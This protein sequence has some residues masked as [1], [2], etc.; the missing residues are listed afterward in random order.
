MADGIVYIVDDDSDAK[1]AVAAIVTEMGVEA[2]TYASAEAFLEAYRGE[3][4][5][6]LV[7]DVRMLHMSGLELQE[8][9]AAAGET[10]SVVVLTA[11]AD[12]PITVRA[13]K[14]GAITLLEKPCRDNAL[15]DAIRDGLDQDREAM[16]RQAQQKELKDRL[17]SL[18]TGER[19]VLDLILEGEPN[20][21]IA[22]KLD[23][24]IRTVESRRQNIFKKMHAGS[25][26]ELVRRV[27]DANQGE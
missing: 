20:K 18:T 1:E 15:W 3:R 6:C 27:I 12:T 24:S 10:L 23:V 2:K 25:V 19:E 16:N 5:G 14:Q 11:Y 13:I 26:A 21:A 8:Q 7:T 4:P 9:L 22:H 17:A